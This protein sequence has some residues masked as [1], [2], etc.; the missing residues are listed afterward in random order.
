MSGREE[1]N[2]DAL[3]DRLYEA[4]VRAIAANGIGVVG[5][6]GRHRLV[7]EWA[8]AHGNLAD[9][10]CEIIGGPVPQHGKTCAANRSAIAVCDCGL[11]SPA[12][13]QEKRDE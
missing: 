12:L 1:R 7:M 4:A 8:V 3:F 5:K 13:S 6:D 2:S 9:V 10:L 11:P